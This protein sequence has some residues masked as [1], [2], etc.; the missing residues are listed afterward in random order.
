MQRTLRFQV[1]TERSALRQ[2]LP[3]LTSF[4]GAPHHLR[5]PADLAFT[6]PG[7][8]LND[9]F[10][11]PVSSCRES[12]QPPVSSYDLLAHEAMHGA[13]HG[14]PWGVEFGREAGNGTCRLTVECQHNRT[15]EI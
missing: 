6:A 7:R 1:S 4:L 12:P 9:L 15:L 14:W 5:R 8:V 2:P 10:R 13:T 11:E 3:L